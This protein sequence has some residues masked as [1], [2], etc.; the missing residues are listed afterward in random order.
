MYQTV[1]FSIQPNTN[2]QLFLVAEYEYKY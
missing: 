1:I 2:I